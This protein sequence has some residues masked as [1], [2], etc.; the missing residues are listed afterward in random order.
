M[1]ELKYNIILR[2]F[3]LGLSLT[4]SSQTFANRNPTYHV[5]CVKI[6]ADGYVTLDVW[7]VNLKSRYTSHQ[8]RKDALHSILFA[9]IG[10]GSDCT[11][12]PPIL[13]VQSER[14]SFKK[15]E[16]VFF[17]RKGDWIL[18]TRSDELYNTQTTIDQSGNKIFRVILSKSELQKYLDEKKVTERLNK[19]F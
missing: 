2:W 15:M 3:L 6:G 7:D 14:E 4:Y 9:G 12:Q 11:P 16:K 19:N 5:A 8:A 10:G 1:M 13:N 18:F 17:S